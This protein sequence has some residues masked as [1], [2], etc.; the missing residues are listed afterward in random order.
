LNI[1]KNKSDTKLDW[2]ANNTGDNCYL[3]GI[4]RKK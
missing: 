4:I 2:F 3:R 1:K